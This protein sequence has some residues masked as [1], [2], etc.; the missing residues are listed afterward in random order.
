MR[1]RLVRHCAESLGNTE[2]GFEAVERALA[3][4][5]Y[6]GPPRAELGGGIVVE[7]SGE[8]LIF[9]REQPGE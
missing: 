1:R 7:R 8:R 6:D 4:G 3:V 9:Y 5:Q 2:L